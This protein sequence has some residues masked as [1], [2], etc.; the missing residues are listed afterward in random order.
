MRVLLTNDDGVSSAG[1]SVLRD[2]LCDE[3]EVWTVAPDDERSGTSHAITLRDAVR[4]RKLDDRSYSCS[5]SPADCVLYTYLGA[6]RVIPD[7]V[8]SGVNRGPNLG[9]DIIYSGTAAAARQAALMG[10]P[11]VAVSATFPLTDRS[12]ALAAEFVRLNLANLV[13][14]WQTDTFWNINVPGAGNLD[15]KPAEPARRVYNDTLIEFAA[16]NGDCYMFLKGTVSEGVSKGGTDWDIVRS[17]NI[18]VSPIHLHPQVHPAAFADFGV[19]ESVEPFK[20]PDG[21][22]ATNLET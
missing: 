3:H 12:F 9:T 5:G 15:V 11:A 22:V 8:V 1:L 21:S 4:L 6:I 17:G 7:V 10:Y 16:P 2:S 18:A 13:R 20:V 14:R 19:G